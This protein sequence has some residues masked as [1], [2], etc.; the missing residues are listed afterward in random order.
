MEDLPG[1]FDPGI[2]VE[3]TRFISTAKNFGIHPDGVLTT[4][5]NRL[6]SGF[7]K[8]VDYQ[9]MLFANFVIVLNVYINLPVVLRQVWLTLPTNHQ[10]CLLHVVVL[11]C[12]LQNSETLLLELCS[13][14]ELHIVVRKFVEPH[15]IDLDFQPLGKVCGE[16]VEKAGFPELDFKRVI[17]VKRIVLILHALLDDR[18]LF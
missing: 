14:R 8:V 11:V 7:L 1:D 15:V 18:K 13:L 9:S 6:K 2:I 17:L 12:S 5:A 16:V 4:E 10:I 3:H